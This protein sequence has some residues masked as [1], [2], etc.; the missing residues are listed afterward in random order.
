M[1]FIGTDM[2]YVT[3]AMSSLVHDPRKLSGN[4]G[5]GNEAVD[6]GHP[7]INV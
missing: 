1:E 4:V 2:G 3:F 7:G 6:Y 5:T